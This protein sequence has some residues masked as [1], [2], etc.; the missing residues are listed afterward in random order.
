MRIPRPAGCRLLLFCRQPLIDGLLISLGLL[1]VSLTHV[2]ADT[3]WA[4]VMTCL[5]GTRTTPLALDNVSPAG[6]CHGSADD[7]T[8]AAFTGASGSQIEKC[9]AQA[10]SSAVGS[11]RYSDTY[12]HFDAY[13]FGDSTACVSFQTAIFDPPA[14]TTST[15]RLLAAD[16]D[17]QAA[18]CGCKDT[19]QFIYQE[20]I[21]QIGWGAA[22]GDFCDTVVTFAE[23]KL[24]SRYCKSKVI[25]NGK[26]VFKFAETLCEHLV[27]PVTDTVGDAF[28]PV[29]EAGVAFIK[30]QIGLDLNAANAELKTDAQAIYQKLTPF[31]DK[32]CGPIACSDGSSS[33]GCSKTKSLAAN[34]VATVLQLADTGYCDFAAT[35]S[36]NSSSGKCRAALCAIHTL[37]RP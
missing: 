17:A 18:H 19:M 34:S 37:D 24:G 36:S 20:A 16:N 25:K 13:P 14:E 30:E 9:A 33:S 12:I 23:G 5:D 11:E 29:C 8:Y 15:R 21:L 1:G 35:T 22:S 7:C 3:Y 26:A 4:C 10:P 28:K 32:I 6:Q 31:V 27:S 2:T